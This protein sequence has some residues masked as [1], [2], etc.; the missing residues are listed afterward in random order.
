MDEQFIERRKDYGDIISRLS[1]IEISIALLTQ[2][3]DSQR[4]KLTQ[5]IEQFGELTVKH[6][7]TLYGN[8]NIGLLTKLDRLEVSNK[9]QLWHFRTL[10]VVI[11][12]IVGKIVA[13]LFGRK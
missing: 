4:E 5:N 8:N 10:W 6:E 11:L 13:D 7:K 3:I 9:T 12:G 1:K 2:T